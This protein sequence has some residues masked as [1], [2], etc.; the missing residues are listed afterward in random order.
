MIY[1]PES[2]GI[3]VSDRAA[4]GTCKVFNGENYELVKS[5]K[6]A[7]GA[8]NAAYDA[9]SHYQYVSAGGCHAGMPITLIA[10]VSAL[11]GQH[12][13]DIPVDS[14]NIQAMAFESSGPKMYADLADVNKI[15][16]IDREKRSIITTWSLAPQCQKPYALSL[17][18][19]HHRLL[20]GAVC[21]RR[22]RNGGSQEKCSF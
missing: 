7:V 9:P 8:D 13:G 19:A 3:F 2:N 15:A 17:D 10:I 22:K 16:V 11:N 20:S 1:H 12:L 21:S 14:V 4:D 5:I 18:S 6:L